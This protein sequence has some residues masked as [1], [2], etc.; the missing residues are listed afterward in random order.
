MKFLI[1][2][3]ILGLAGLPAIMAQ[4]NPVPGA[5]ARIDVTQTQ[6]AP[7]GGLLLSLQIVAAKSQGLDLFI[8]APPRPAGTEPVEGDDDPLPISLLGSKL[9]DVATGNVIECLATL[10]TSPIVGPMEACTSLAPGAW[11][12]MGVA[13]PQ[14]PPVKSQSGEAEIQTF[15]L[16][17]P[18]L[19]LETTFKVNPE[20][21]TLSKK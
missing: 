12:Q 5:T 16:F 9:T 15:K 8:P 19:K 1:L 10:P 2:I 7:D 3:L 6:K 13:F 20:T 14:I 17:V 11:I 18:A 4:S 21:G